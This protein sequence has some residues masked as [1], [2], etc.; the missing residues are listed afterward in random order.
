MKKTI[1]LQ[2]FR[3]AFKDYN[4][5]NNFSYEGLE[6]LFD[7]L[8]NLEDDTGSAIELDVIAICCDY[9]EYKNLEEFQ[10]DY[11]DDYKT[12]DDIRDKTDVIKIDGVGF[13]IQ[14]F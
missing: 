3:Q 9:N 12:I 13:I 11:S 8:N 10:R 2:N 7:Y 14:Q 6:A 5:E 1:N 4:R